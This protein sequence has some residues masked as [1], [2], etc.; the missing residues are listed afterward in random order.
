MRFYI[1]AR[2]GRKAEAKAL[3]VRLIKLGHEVTSTW[4]DQAED[5]MLY[6]EGPQA[7]G[8]FA[9]KDYAEIDAADGL[10]ALS[11]DETNTWGRGGRHVEFGYAA[12]RGKRLIV[13]GPKENLFHYDPDV[14]LYDSVKLFLDSVGSY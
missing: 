8:N 1:A 12:G 11:E 14:D 10:V 6:T 4:V 3:A 2:Y 9:R 7:A 5:E 13:V